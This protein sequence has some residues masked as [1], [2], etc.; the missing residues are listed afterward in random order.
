MV[1]IDKTLIVFVCHTC[2]KRYDA[3]IYNKPIE[4]CGQL[5]TRHLSSFREFY[6]LSNAPSELPPGML[7]TQAYEKYQKNPKVKTNI[8]R[9]KKSM[10]ATCEFCKN[11]GTWTIEVGDEYLYC[12]GWHKE[13][14]INFSKETKENLVNILTRKWS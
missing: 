7:I 4:C 14:C 8:Y 13:K 10:K 5:I 12:C 2:G 1:N 11:R 6:E 3:E 9:S